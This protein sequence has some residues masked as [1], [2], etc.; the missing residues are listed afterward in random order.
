MWSEAAHL[1][2]EESEGMVRAVLHT[3]FCLLRIIAQQIKTIA[4]SCL[5]TASPVNLQLSCDLGYLQSD[6]MISEQRDVIKMIQEL[7]SGR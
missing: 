1:L 2:A 3:R 4:P 7:F 6:G 5:F